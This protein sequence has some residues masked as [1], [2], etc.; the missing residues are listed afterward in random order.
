MRIVQLTPGSG[1]SFY[2][3]NCVRD[4]ALVR[5]LRQAG[6]EVLF[7][8]VYLPIEADGGE[9]LSDRKIFFGGINVY[10]QQKL[11]LFRKTPRW[12]DAMLDRPGLLRWLG[13]RAGATDAAD[14]AEVTISMPQGSQG[15]QVKELDRLVDFLAAGE[16][17]DVICLSN[18]LLL[19]L[20]SKLKR[21]LNATVVSL[22]QDEDIFLDALPDEYRERAWRIM[23]EKAA[24]AD[25]FIAVSTYYGD[26][27]TGR[28]HLQPGRVVVAWP[29][30]DLAGYRPAADPAD[31]PAIGFL[32]RLCADKGFDTLVKAFILLRSSGE[33]PHLKLRACGGCTAT[34][35][36]FLAECMQRLAEAGLAGDVEFVQDFSRAGRISFLQS[37]SVLSVPARHKE[38]FA[39]YALEAMAAGVPV[40][41]P[42]EG[43]FPELID[44]T[45]GG[46]L[47]SDNS[48]ESLAQAI[49]QLLQDR[50]RRRRLGVAGRR[51]VEATFSAAHAADRFVGACRRFCPAVAAEPMRR[52]P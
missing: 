8:P 48:P 21:K 52:Q 18:A 40:V 35:K 39:L 16:R 31:G 12:I 51:A 44:Q 22:L 29:G 13:K 1:G 42:P 47:S 2:C 11:A 10:L 9:A 23:A 20:V 34:D 25:G 24:E 49:S 5:A 14:M 3:L 15:R 6:N 41:L 4:V 46:I 38:G 30:I 50:Q 7:V 37:L 27:M 43:S 28:L 26:V 17:P 33:H 32:E 45:S 19:G 36:P